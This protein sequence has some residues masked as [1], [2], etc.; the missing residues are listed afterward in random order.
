MAGIARNDD[1]ARAKA[2]ARR[3]WWGFMAMSIGAFMAVLDIQIVASS[4][5]QIQAGLSASIDEIQWVQTAY[6]IAEVIAIPLSGYLA[7]LLS[8]RVYFVIS[9]VG[10]TLASVACALAWDLGSMVCFRVLQGFLGGGMIPTSFAAMFL[11]FPD[12][13]DRA[14][15]Q[16]VG[17]MLTMM[18]PALGP[19]VG[20]YI[21][22]FVS[23]H[24]LFLIN[25]VPGL[26]CAWGVWRLVDVDR[27]RPEMFRLTD[28]PGLLLMA[29]FLASLE[30][31]LDEGPRHDWLSERSVA[32]TATLAVIGGAL[33]FWR[34]F[35]AE[36]PI[37]DLRAF[38]NRNFA[39]T[40]LVSSLIGLCMFTLSYVT[41]VFLGQVRGYNSLQ[42]GEIMMVQGLSMVFAAP[43]VARLSRRMDPRL[44]IAIG[45]ALL[46]IGAFVNGHLTAE[47]GYGE[48]L[49]PQILRGCGLIF[50]F[51]PMTNL[52]LGTLPLS[53]VNNASGLYTLTRNLGG[54][55]GLALVATMINER[56]W[57]HW[58]TLAESTRAS[59][60]PVR[61]MLLG[62]HQAGT[63]AEDPL[64]TIARLA[65]QQ[66]TAMSYADIYLLLSAAVV[67]ALLFVPLLAK[68]RAAA[69]LAHFE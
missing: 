44:V 22:A 24:W 38:R 55:V 46:A 65:Q 52:A 8:T 53:E 58:Q 57:L 49:L 51:I 63:V 23:W 43:L 25:L 21:T 45:L 48:F 35:T 66:A 29:T 19:T 30:Y 13:R 39:L 26:I 6:L 59:R 12:D 47:W 69:D 60:E 9:A 4:I 36:H 27:P 40:S 14:R 68:P 3:D 50:A 54:A 67:F 64:L 62:P 28:W 10:F 20:G 2:R 37:V 11:L 18:A 1:A 17:G 31:T 42:I 56:T 15:P 16:L 33:F 34:S 7:R 32:I 41:P 61:A 5:N